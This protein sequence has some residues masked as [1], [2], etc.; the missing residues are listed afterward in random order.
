MLS[1]QKKKLHKYRNYSLKSYTFYNVCVIYLVDLP[2]GAI[3]DDF[4]KLEDTSGILKW[5]TKI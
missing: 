1:S 2:I 5:K 3:A 4:D